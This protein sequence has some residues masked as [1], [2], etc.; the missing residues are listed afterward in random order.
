[1]TATATITKFL[2]QKNKN[3]SKSRIFLNSLI[4]AYLLFAYARQCYRYRGRRFAAPP[5]AA[6]CFSVCFYYYC[7]FVVLLFCCACLLCNDVVVCLLISTLFTAI[8]FLIYIYG[9]IPKITFSAHD[10]YKFISV[11][12]CGSLYLCVCVFTY[13]HCHYVC[14]NSK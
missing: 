5:N 8:H 12:L 2:A 7:C 9:K 3:K 1:M 14:A 13:A 11:A 10:I 6:V 4:V